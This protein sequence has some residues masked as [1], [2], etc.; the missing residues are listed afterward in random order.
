[1]PNRWNGQQLN[2]DSQWF[3]RSLLDEIAK[4]SILGPYGLNWPFRAQP[5]PVLIVASRKVGK[6]SE[7]LD[8]AGASRVPTVPPSPCAGVESAHLGRTAPGTAAAGLSF[9]GWC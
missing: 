4:T 8:Q 7:L 6:W 2:A 9:F 3:S 1:M 5:N